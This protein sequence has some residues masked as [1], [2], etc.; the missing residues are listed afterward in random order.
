MPYPVFKRMFLAIC[1]LIGVS[2]TLWGCG[3][4]GGSSSTA[5]PNGPIIVKREVVA[6]GIKL[7]ISIA[8]A[9]DGRI[10]FS[11]FLSGDIRII[12]DGLLNH[13]PFYSTTPGVGNEGLSGIALD[14]HFSENGYVY[15][16]HTD[17]GTRTSR[18]VRVTDD[19][20]HG[21]A[22]VTLVDNIP[23]GGHNGGRL[24]FDEDGDTLYISTGDAG[25]PN[26]SQ[27]KTSLA[28]KI[29]KLN[30][31]LSPFTPRIFAA[32]FRN[33]FGLALRSTTGDLYCSDNG[34]TCDDEINIVKQSGNYGWSA[35][36]PCGDTDTRFEQ[37]IVRFAQSIAPT[38][39]AFYEASTIPELSDELLVADFNTGSL[40]AYLLDESSGALIGEGAPLISGEYGFLVD[41]TVGPDGAIYVATKD[42][43]VRLS[44]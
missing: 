29:L 7:P 6:S 42:S 36:Q 16:F 10:F 20:G 22:P 12:K 40:R 13:S 23:A 24:V 32:G 18:I 26:L 41:V 11:E 39:I 3:G 34:P 19:N 5:T 8:F 38:G 25:A 28:G 15:F 33:V 21:I 31:R 43:I 30:V 14:P 1:C 9:P 4:G 44:R 2:I 37:P 27:D 17:A 35:T